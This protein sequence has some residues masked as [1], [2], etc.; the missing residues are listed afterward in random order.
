MCRL[1]EGEVEL[2]GLI[3][4]VAAGD[5]A[6]LVSLYDATSRTVFGLVLR[7]TGDRSAA[8]EVMVE[9]Y[10]KALRLAPQFNPNRLTGLAWLLSIARLCAVDRRRASRREPIRIDRVESPS[11]SSGTEQ[12]A[13]EGAPGAARAIL[14]SLP[15]EQRV[16][17][18]L[19]YY[20]GMSPGEIAAHL[21]QPRA[22]VKTRTRL[23][24]IRLAEE[25]KQDSKDR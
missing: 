13:A 25:L 23:G 6:A 4:K 10:R 8:E 2:S 5:A 3:Q 20:G 18:E 24:M 7:I 15:P 12:P 14:E 19:A 22:A 9:V 16:A 11:P 1:V 17:L 21:G